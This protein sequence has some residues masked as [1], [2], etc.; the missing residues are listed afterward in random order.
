LARLV[1]RG[2]L[3]SEGSHL[4]LSAPTSSSVADQ[5]FG[6]IS[7]GIHLTLCALASPG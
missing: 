7:M 6:A 2:D 5:G 4:I 1:G 3:N